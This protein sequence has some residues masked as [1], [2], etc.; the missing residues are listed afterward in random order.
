MPPLPDDELLPWW[1]QR[2]VDPASPDVV[3]GAG[4]S[5]SS[6]HRNWALLGTVGGAERAVIDPR[7]A[8]TPWPDG[9]SLDWWVGADDTW[10]LPS[11]AVGVRQRLLDESPVIET[12]MRIPGGELIHRAWAVAA[13]EGVPDG[14]AVVVE[15]EN[16]S[17]VPV[18]VALA[19]RPFNPVGRSPVT[20]VTLDGT[21]VSVDGRPAMILPKQP[22]RVAVG[23]AAVDAVVPTVGGD[24]TSTWPD[25][26]A[27]CSS[28]RA[29]AAFLFPLPHTATVRVLLPL[30]AAR[31]GAGRRRPD[32]APP[33]DPRSAPDADRVV[34]GWEVQTRRAPR[35]ELPE[36]RLGAGVAAMRRFAL[37][38]AAGEDVAS[39]P[40]TVV[41]GLDTAELSIA[42]DEHGLH[43]EAERLVLGFA[44]R[45]GLDG[46]FAGESTR[47]DA[48]AAWLHALGAH[49]RLTGDPTLAESL[50]GPVA[51]A[52]HHLR[53]RLG[54]RRGR[55]ADTANGLFPS[56]PTP[57][58]VPGSDGSTYHDALWARR[59]LLDAAFVL[60]VAGQPEAAVEPRALAADLTAALVAT[61]GADPSPGTGPGRPSGAGALATAVALAA[62]LGGPEPVPAELAAAATLATAI[63]PAL[64]KGGV[65][66]APGDAGMSPRLTAWIGSA[67]LA[68][69]RADVAEPLAWL[70]ERGDPVWAWPELVH[71]R[72]GGGCAGEG[73]HA[74]STAAVLQFVRRL[75]VHESGGGLALLPA[76]PDA[77]LGQAIEA[78]A[79]PTSYGR[80][81]YAVRWHGERPALLWELEPHAEP[82][83]AAVLA[84]AGPFVIT[85]PGLD[86]TWSTTELSGEALLAAPGRVPP[87]PAASPDDGDGRVDHHPDHAA[88]EAPEVAVELPPGGVSG[89][90]LDS[91]PPPGGGSFS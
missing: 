35:L 75:A 42:L 61:L 15:L 55:R 73:H 13:G 25:S 60:E 47:V 24:A 86:P 70:I 17:P 63:S 53:R 10:H 58:W 46:S 85:A 50:V 80:L 12:V 52:A 5:V 89:R 22:S 64:V 56:V 31:P 40:P 39:W 27:R 54:A 3:P 77:W 57:S 66:H 28:G 21:L 87:P 26:G 30:V 36:P 65:W 11:R 51:K 67:R 4:A 18:A 38:H 19:V 1:W 78:H 90:V 9:W 68:A 74:A 83:V 71:P 6:T 84:A 32:G 14:G 91:E 8:I 2:Q 7:G 34:S 69:T 37:L 79:V 33:L 29:S 43:A 88:T 62:T 59:G 45:Q 81:S 49:V 72:S 23:S 76:V 16:A 20:A 82:V 48:T 41:G 44:D